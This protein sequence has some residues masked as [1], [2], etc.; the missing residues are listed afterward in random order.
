MNKAI[1]VT[2]TG[3][4]VG[5]TYICGLLVKKLKEQGVNVG[6]YKPV[7]SGADSIYSS[8]IGYVK[9]FSQISQNINSM[10]SYIFTNP[11]SPHLAS[12]ME[13]KTIDK[14]KILYD[15][16]NIKN[17][18]EYTIVEGSGGIV[19]PIIYNN[20]EKL[21]LENIIN[22][23]GLD[24]IIVADAGLGTINFTL[25]TIEYIKSKNI[26]IK[27][28]IFNNYKD[29]IMH[30]DNINLIYN[31]TSVPIIAKVGHNDKNINILSDFR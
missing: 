24:V 9:S 25:L 21:F 11:V 8:D 14:N 31:T 13:N 23:L 26:N 22:M 18:F 7:L 16:N 29:I 1:F 27:G 10:G 28:I 19:C 12:K 20:S 30:N 17:K 4:D 2:G 6:Y 3:T 5:K 15:F